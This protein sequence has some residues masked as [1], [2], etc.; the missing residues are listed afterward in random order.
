MTFSTTCM[1]VSHETPTGDIARV[2]VVID[3]HIAMC[4]QKDFKIKVH[5][6]TLGVSHPVFWCLVWSY[7]I[8]HWLVLS[9]LAWSSLV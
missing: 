1:Y 2:D 9:V 6:R 7:L 4:Q 3:E 5:P 8:L